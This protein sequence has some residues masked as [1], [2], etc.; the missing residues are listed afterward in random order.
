MA[1]RY[2]TPSPSSHAS[3]MLRAALK[4]PTSSPSNPASERT[5]CDDNPTTTTDSTPQAPV[6]HL[7][8]LDFRASISSSTTGSSN[9]AESGIRSIRRLVLPPFHYG[10]PFN[11]PVKTRLATRCK[12]DIFGPH[13][14]HNS[15]RLREYMQRCADADLAAH[16][17][18]LRT[19]AWV[20]KLRRDVAQAEMSHEPRQ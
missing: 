5:S 14:R 9:D 18:Y 2:P 19:T 15:S 16:A 6:Y 13:A 12:D 3:S 10:T 4:T 20:R 17:R 7:F 11:P 8:G 1:S